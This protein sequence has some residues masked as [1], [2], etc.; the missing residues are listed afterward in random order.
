[1]FGINALAGRV[2]TPTDD[3]SG[4]PPVVVISYHTWRRHFGGDPSLIGATLNINTGA[5]SVAGVA[6]PG[7]Y[8]DTLRSDPP[9]FWLPLNM[10]PNRRLHRSDLEWL[11][12]IGRLRP[13]VAPEATGSAHGGASAV[14]V[15]YRLR[16]SHSGAA[17]Q[18]GFGG[19]ISARHR[20]ATH[21]PYARTGRRGP[22]ADGLC[23]RPAPTRDDRCAGPVDR[24]RQRC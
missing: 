4:E 16:R 22:D 3:R 2:L 1:M 12:L 18:Q 5:Y 11:Y 14:V 17:Q 19:G 9:D 13:D 6:P 10:E 21:P 8:G 23:C 24:L 7:F 20:Q 15:V